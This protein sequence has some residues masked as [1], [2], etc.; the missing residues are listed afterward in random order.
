MKSMTR[1]IGW[2]A[3]LA[4][5]LVCTLIGA[6][7]T[8][9]ARTQVGAPATDPIKSGAGPGWPTTM[10]PNDFVAQ[11]DNPWFPLR[12]GSEYRYTGLK[13]RT[14]MVDVVSVTARTKRILGVET[15]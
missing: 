12:P 7:S 2:R 8:A 10:S 13:D 5:G 4:L 15:T 6:A 11:V 14:K 9:A 3:F 1:S